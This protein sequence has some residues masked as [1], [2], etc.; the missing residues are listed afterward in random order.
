MAVANRI[1]HALT[2]GG[3]KYLR[4][5]DAHWLFGVTEGVEVYFHP[6]AGGAPKEAATALVEGLVA[7][8]V[9]A[10]LKEKNAPGNPDNTIALIIGIKPR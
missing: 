4:P 9:A 5:K 2:A 10:A 7:Q 1:S 3:W 6:E 8:G